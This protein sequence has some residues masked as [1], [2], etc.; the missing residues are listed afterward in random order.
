MFHGFRTEHFFPGPGRNPPSGIRFFNLFFLYCESAVKA[1]GKRSKHLSGAHPLPLRGHIKTGNPL[2]CLQEHIISK[3]LSRASLLQNI[4]YHIINRMLS[5]RCLPDSDI[6]INQENHTPSVRKSLRPAILPADRRSL[7][8]F[9]FSSRIAVILISPLLHLR[10]RLILRNQ[11]Q[12]KRQQHTVILCGSFR[13]PGCN[14]IRIIIQMRPVM[15][16]LMR[17]DCLPIL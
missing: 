14:S 17:K 10:N 12:T 3:C 2:Y 1:S 16:H 13:I 6:R 4:Q 5:F 15:H 8:I 9:Q 7:L 11:P